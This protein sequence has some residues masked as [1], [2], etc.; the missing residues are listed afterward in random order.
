[1]K[2]NPMN[3]ATPPLPKL[4]TNARLCGAKTRAGSSCRCPAM[5]GKTRCLRHGGKSPGAPMGEANGS[6]R[7]GG[8]TNE[9]IALRQ[10]ASRLLKAIRS[11]AYV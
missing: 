5:K 2:G 6:Y 1:M 9:A 11:A 7:H 3:E 10:E 8:E 4:M